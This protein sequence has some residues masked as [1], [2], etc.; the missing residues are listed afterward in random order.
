MNALLFEAGMEKHPRC[1]KDLHR[2]DS[3]EEVGD[4]LPEI[5]IVIFDQV[6][7]VVDDQ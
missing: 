3:L 6:F 5:F 1:Q 2:I 4:K 7:A